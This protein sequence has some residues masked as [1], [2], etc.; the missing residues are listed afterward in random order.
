MA[1]AAATVPFHGRK[2][3]TGS[4]THWHKGRHLD[5]KASSLTGK[6]RA[7]AGG[8]QGPGATEPPAPRPLPTEVTHGPRCADHS[9]RGFCS[10]WP[11]SSL[12]EPC[13]VKL[14]PPCLGFASALH[15]SLSLSRKDAPGQTV[16]VLSSVLNRS[17]PRGI[18]PD[19][20]EPR[21]VTRAT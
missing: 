7:G 20:G 3:V 14:R 9:K 10:L 16:D 18:L 17:T 4:G 19:G 2:C 8:E 11:K 15:W 5:W 6:G 12:E 1:A 21:E 13:A